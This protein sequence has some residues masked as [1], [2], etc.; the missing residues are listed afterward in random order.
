MHRSEN[1]G[2]KRLTYV[3]NL[4]STDDTQHFV[5]IPNLL[6]EL[7]ALGWD[8]QLV[9][10]RGGQGVQRVAGREVRYL[11]I[12][13]RWSRLWPLCKLLF[14]NR[15]AGGRLVF[16][17][18]SRS[19]GGLS[20]LLGRLFGWKTLFWLSDVK[21]DFDA[22][23]KGR[24]GYW[25]LWLLFRIIDRLVT[26]PETMVDYYM[27]TY[28]LDRSKLTLLYNDIDITHASPASLQ[29][30]NG[31]L[32]VLLVHHLSPAR[33]T[34]RY[35][36]AILEGLRAFAAEGAS[37]Q[38]DIVG[39]GPDENHLK[40]IVTDFGTDVSVAFHG[41]VPNRKLYPFYSAAS[42]FIMPSYREGFP[43]VLV[44]AMAH[45][46]PIVSTDAGGSRD[47]FGDGQQKFVVSRDDPDGFAAALAQLLRS[48]DL[49]KSLAQENL[50]R[51]P[52][53]STPAVA[54]M[55]DEALSALLPPSK[56]T[57]AQ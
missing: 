6:N 47:L 37:V 27:R 28:G 18:I 55:Y 48:I 33:E 34:S 19:S 10:E 23:R 24:K 12:N 11:S 57:I 51:V 15:M 4:V 14:R 40:T 50:E 1:Q 53:Y 39:G 36:P 25:S 16:I 29:D 3:V 45:G 26:G 35:L 31:S 42:V 13:G 2:N 17:R 9:S 41:P 38:L 32:R 8:I 22:S 56:A 21:E 7:E 52:R 20:G 44:E 43:R 30:K 46:L 49:R 54:R 5:H